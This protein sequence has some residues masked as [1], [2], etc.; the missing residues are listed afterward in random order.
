MLLKDRSTNQLIASSSRSI[1]VRRDLNLE[2][3][4]IKTASQASTPCYTAK[5]K[6][7]EYEEENQS[8]T[9]PTPTDF[10]QLK[11]SHQLN[12]IKKKIKNKKIKKKRFT[13]NMRI[14]S[15]EFE[16]EENKVKRELCRKNHSRE[17]K[18]E[19]LTRWK[20]FVEEISTEIPFFEYFENHFQ[21]HK[22][23]CVLIKTNWTKENRE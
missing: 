8:Q 18:I 1:L 11:H 17:E 14:L 22:K 12:T 3:Q 15:D 10:E 2:L 9:S 23:S 6:S 16:F 5:P 21:W 19:V 13:P 7:I 20:D 4:G